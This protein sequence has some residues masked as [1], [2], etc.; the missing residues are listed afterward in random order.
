M[1]RTSSSPIAGRSLL[2]YAHYSEVKTLR[3]RM[4]PRTIAP[5]WRNHER[6]F[7]GH[8]DAGGRVFRKQPFCG[9]LVPPWIDCLCGAD[10]L[11]CRRNR[12]SASVQL[13][14]A[15][16]LCIFLHTLRRLFFLDNRPPCYGRRMVSCCATSVGKSRGVAG[17]I[18]DSLR[19]DPPP[20]SPPLLVDGYPDRRGGFTRFQ[21]RLSQLEFLSWAHRALLRLF[22]IRIALFA[23]ALGPAGQRRKSAVHDLDAQGRVY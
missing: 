9:P 4:F 21:T 18:G 6:A 14:M 7:T 12:E 1:G 23:T 11:R 22:Y 10:A 5:N 13:F 15:L 16:C 8:A 17:S 3:L 2:T 19:A 20:P